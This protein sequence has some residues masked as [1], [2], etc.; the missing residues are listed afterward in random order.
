[1]KIQE[2]TTEELMNIDGGGYVSIF[3]NFFYTA[4]RTI[5]VANEISDSLRDN[6]NYANAMVYK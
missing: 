5:I 2:L 6:P 3:Y 4:M 1:M